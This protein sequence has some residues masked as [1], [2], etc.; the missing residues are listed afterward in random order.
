MSELGENLV[1]IGSR[2]TSKLA[3]NNVQISSKARLT[4]QRI[5]V[6]IGLEITSI[7]AVKWGPKRQR[8][9]REK[10]SE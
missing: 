10:S 5:D 2:L 1:Q 4:R 7:L 3:G 8:T 6:T 9:E